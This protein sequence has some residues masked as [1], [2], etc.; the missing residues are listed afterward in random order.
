VTPSRSR[1]A[2]CVLLAV[3]A[4]ALPAPAG[5]QPT[6]DPS[7]RLVVTSLRGVVGPATDPNPDDDQPAPEDLEVRVLVEN[8]G[9]EDLTD[10][11]LI[12]EIHRGVDARSLLAAALDRDEA[13]T[14]LRTAVTFDVREGGTVR[15][16][17]IA[18]VDVRVP[19]DRAGWSGTNGVF[20]VALT[21]MRGSTVL[22]RTV[23]AVVHMT[24]PVDNPLETTVVWPL[25]ALTTRTPEGTYPE[26]LP[27][28][29]TPG[30]RLDRL[31]LAAERNI[32]APIL[33]APDIATVEE[34]IDRADG[35]STVAGETVEADD[36][37]AR[38]AANLL[39]RIRTL[40][41]ETAVEPVAGAYAN[42][43]V[44]ALATGPE[45][46][47]ELAGR[48]VE[49]ERTRMQTLLGRAPDLSAFL[50]AGPLTP[51][52]LDVLPADRVLVTADQLLPDAEL[53][54]IPGI[55]PSRVLLRSAEGGVFEALVADPVLTRLLEDPPNQH[56]HV[57]I[58]QRFVAETALLYQGAPAVAGRTLLALP[59][60]GWTPAAGT[61]EPLLSGLLDAPWLAFTGARSDGSSPPTGALATSAVSLP[62][63]VAAQLVST[64]RLVTA[65]RSALASVD[66]PVMNRAISELEDDLLRA[67]T[68]ASLAGGGGRAVE[69]IQGVRRVVEAAFGSV[70]IAPSA[71]I[72]LTSDTGDIPV[73][74]QRTAGGPIE[75]MVEVESAGRLV[76]DE[77]AQVKARVPLPERG[78][79]TV[80]FTTRAV[81]RGTFPVT[82]SVWDPTR[83]HLLDTA[84]LSVRS[85]A[86]SRP[87][88]IVTG[89]VVALL[90]LSGARRRRRPK[91]EVVS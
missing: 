45:G 43:D 21:L 90:L 44:A 23:T 8:D 32:Q 27:D 56:G 6:P 83:T 84:T 51:A 9:A 17:D 34:L 37:P 85:T 47:A 49:L 62:A 20:P 52:A 19:A 86:I 31:L 26:A 68:P 22:D 30:G 82:V 36:G 48:A 39:R 64:R 35:F 13:S 67:L 87:A 5:A 58:R 2:A 46:V 77:A 10:L 89:G 24:D 65:L 57:L 15:P 29:L 75:V 18:G 33:L 53:E 12:V 3:L 74:L 54:V 14:P 42:A 25:E 69:R 16:G 63:A 11:S 61:A 28:D 66:T 88:L 91:L 79:T 76:W 7:G 1:R 73:T 72:T 59:S 80:S 78:V 40:V 50:A 81:S 60:E 38:Q 4:A 70:R 55:P 71:R 41:A